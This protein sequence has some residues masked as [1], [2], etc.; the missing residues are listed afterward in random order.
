MSQ[1]APYVVFFIINYLFLSPN[2]LNLGTAVSA[3]GDINGDGFADVLI[4]GMYT[5]SKWI[6][7]FLF[8]EKHSLNVGLFVSY[9]K[10]IF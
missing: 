1:T 3:A 6:I 5:L 8:S 4:G 7:S 2:I 9:K 10:P